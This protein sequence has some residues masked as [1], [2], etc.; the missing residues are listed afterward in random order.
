M[1]HA[2]KSLKS[3]IADCARFTASETIPE[4]VSSLTVLVREAGED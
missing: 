4:L 1:N 3:D 2:S